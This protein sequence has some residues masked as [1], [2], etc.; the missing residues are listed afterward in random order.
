VG[1]KHDERS[2]SFESKQK[3]KRSREQE[4]NEGRK[5][6]RGM[7]RMNGEQGDIRFPDIERGER[8]L[9]PESRPVYRRLPQEI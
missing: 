9:K 5:I 8:T 3:K 7:V 2:R 1:V 4:T 6:T